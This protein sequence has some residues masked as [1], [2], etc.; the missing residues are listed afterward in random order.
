MVHFVGAGP[1]APDLITRRG[2]ALLADADCIIYA[3]SLVNPALLGLAKPGCAIYN[4]AEMTLEQVLDTIRAAEK[5][6][7]TTVRLHTG[8]PC[9]YGAIREQMDA[10]DADG[11]PYDDTPGVSS[12]CGAA[13]ALC[14]EY[15]LPNVSQTVII[16]RMEGRTPVPEAEQLEK[17][18]A[19]GATMVIFLSIGLVDKVQQALLKSGGYRSDTPAAVV[20]K[21]TW[22]EQKVVRCTV[23][24]LAEETRKNGITKTAL[25]VVGD[26]LGENYERSK[27]YDPFTAKGEAL[28]HRLAEA[29]PGSV[30]RCGG[31][32]TLKGWTA[33]HFAQ[34]EALIFVGAVGIAVRAIA[35]HCRSKA[36]D[37]AVVA[38]DEGGNFAVSGHLGGANALA[39]ALAKA[40][41]AVPVITT[42]TDVNGLFAVDLW[43]KA[44]NCAVLEPERIKRVSGALL[45][46]QTVRY[47]SPW[48]VAGETPAGVKKA[49]APEAA[50]FALTLTPQGEAL[51]L[52]PRIGVLGVGCRRGTTAQ[53]LEEAFAAFCAASGLSPAAVC[54]AASI[55]LKKDEPGL[56]AFCKVHGWPITFYPADELRAVPGQFTPSAFVASVTGVDNVCE[57]SAVKASGG[58]L[59]LPKTAGGGVTLALAVRPF[60]PDW[61]TEQ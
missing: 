48:P 31:D 42:A 38:V 59:L 60:A 19:H 41:G 36:A 14:A 27:L 5:A 51:H 11:I 30:S 21:A 46:G 40:C 37:P 20:Y 8:D 18:A 4:S 12:F 6:D 15:T 52:V 61:R 3:G 56:A 22:P 44:Q 50:D 33:E 53:Q 2:A 49:D 10:L 25:I 13:A 23:S 45:A 35:P 43:A 26:F 39:R 32:V 57:R 54:A 34:D 17:L 29:L 28:A 47:W 9:L 55:D 24:T 1:G 16:T 58:M 7:G